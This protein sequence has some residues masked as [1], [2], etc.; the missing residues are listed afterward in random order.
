MTVGRI[1]NEPYTRDEFKGVNPSLQPSST[2]R[3]PLKSTAISAK[4][5]LYLSRDEL[6][7]GIKIFMGL[8]KLSLRGSGVRLSWRRGCWDS[9]C[10]LG[11]S[12]EASV[13]TCFGSSL[14]YK[15]IIFVVFI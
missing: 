6:L 11:H 3:I 4:F 12:L 9:W 14:K 10:W 8:N 2:E 13:R 7:L 15:I 5:I 1:D